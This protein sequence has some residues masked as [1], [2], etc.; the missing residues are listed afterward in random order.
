MEM[1]VCVQCQQ[2]LPIDQF[3]W[4]DKA[5]GTRRRE[6][7]KCHNQHVIGQYKNRQKQ[8]EQL[9][10]E[11]KCAKCGE[12][13]GYLLD[14]H[15]IDPNIKDKDISKMVSSKSQ[16]ENISIEIEKCIC[17]CANC[18]REFHYFERE[19]NSFTIKDYL[20]I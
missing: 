6:C 3:Y 15:H 11:T 20:Q 10:S 1:R 13:R 5:R 19:K 18:H 14:Y 17:L 4:R 8:I 9:K 7:K 16:L 2:E 12:N